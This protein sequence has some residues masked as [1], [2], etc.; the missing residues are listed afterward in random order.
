[1]PVN[2]KPSKRQRLI[3]E[4]ASIQRVGEDGPELVQQVRLCPVGPGV[5]REIS[6]IG[7]PRNRS[8]PAAGGGA[9][10]FLAYLF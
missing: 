6:G 2:R 9:E 10:T 3:V 7:R 5:C 1:M 8:I 4:L